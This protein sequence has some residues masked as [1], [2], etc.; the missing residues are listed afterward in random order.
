MY[1][2]N[3]FKEYTPGAIKKLFYKEIISIKGAEVIK[4]PLHLNRVLMGPM[5]KADIAKPA[6][7]EISDEDKHI[8]QCAPTGES[9]S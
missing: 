3:S 4:I 6:G 1:N 2:G 5:V 8:C 7:E 9:P